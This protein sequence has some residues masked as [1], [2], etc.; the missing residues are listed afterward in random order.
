MRGSRDFTAEDLH[1]EE[2]ARFQH[3]FVERRKENRE[4]QLRIYA[5][6]HE[7]RRER[8]KERHCDAMAMM[9]TEVEEAQRKLAAEKQSARSEHRVHRTPS[10]RF[11]DTEHEGATP[12]RHRTKRK[13]SSQRQ[14]KPAGEAPVP[15]AA[16]PATAALAAS[17]VPDD[18]GKPPAQLVAEAKTESTD[19]AEVLPEAVEA[20]PRPLSKKAAKKAKKAAEKKAKEAAAASDAPKINLDDFDFDDEPSSSDDDSLEDLLEQIGLQTAKADESGLESDDS[21]EDRLDDA[22]EGGGSGGL[23]KKRLPWGEW[24]IQ[25]RLANSVGLTLGNHAHASGA[26]TFLPRPI[27]RFP[28]GTGTMS[29][30]QRCSARQVKGWAPL[31][32]RDRVMTPLQSLRAVWWAVRASVRY[33]RELLKFHAGAFG[34]PQMGSGRE[35]QLRKV[36]VVLT[37]K[38]PAID[39]WLKNSVQMPVTDIANPDRQLDLVLWKLPRSFDSAK[40]NG[41][42]WGAKRTKGSS[43]PIL[44]LFGLGGKKSKTPAKGKKGVKE[45]TTAKRQNNEKKKGGGR[46]TRATVK[47]RLIAT[48]WRRT[49]AMTRR[50]M[51]IACR[52]R[53]RR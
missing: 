5:A 4:L 20:K 27:W 45:K 26:T 13:A 15:A 40:K 22:T 18:A 44:K 53:Q 47:R 41:G 19:P 11:A 42:G 6:R 7:R 51:A 36:S 14:S 1:A 49:P 34:D 29:S 37:T 3:Q 17:G 46:P 10:T 38:L 30:A 52:G 12:R 8:A 16:E 9:S 21:E 50:A 24:V 35:E 28:I 2:F 33:H 32:G 31:K 23:Q 43:M 25:D 39:T 48:R